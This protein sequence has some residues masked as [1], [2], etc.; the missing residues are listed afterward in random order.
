MQ[1]PASVYTLQPHNMFL[2]AIASSQQHH[3]SEVHAVLRDRVHQAL[4]QRWRRCDDAPVE[5]LKET[6]LAVVQRRAA[7]V[8]DDATCLL[9]HHRARRVVPDLLA[10]ARGRKPE[11]EVAVAAREE[12]VLDLAVHAQRWPAQAEARRDGAGKCVVGVAR[13]VALH[14]GGGGGF[15]RVGG[16]QPLLWQAWMGH[17]VLCSEVAHVLCL[18]VEQI[19]ASKASIWVIKCSAARWHACNDTVHARAS[20]MCTTVQSPAP[21]DAG[22]HSSSLLPTIS[23]GLARAWCMQRALVRAAAPR[24]GIH[25]TEPWPLSASGIACIAIPLLCWSVQRN[26]GAA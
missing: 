11:E 17:V 18:A 2:D 3:Q 25:R 26:V 1:H 14:E 20:S 12:A 13:V 9:K 6:A 7:R 10:V 22:K 8:T 16:A 5:R 19:A 4:V 23:C 15:R 21:F 24:R